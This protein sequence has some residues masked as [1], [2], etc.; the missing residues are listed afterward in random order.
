MT[1]NVCIQF[2]TLMSRKP[3]MSFIK[4][5]FPSLTSILLISIIGRIKT[6]SEK[7]CLLRNL[8]SSGPGE[9]DTKSYSQRFFLAV[10]LAGTAQVLQS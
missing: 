3:N 9:N 1:Q 10:F 8:T 7:A 5:C 4:N 6:N 2:S